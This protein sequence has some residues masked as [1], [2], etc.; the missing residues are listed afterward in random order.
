[1]QLEQH[2]WTEAEGWSPAPPGGL[3]GKA[4]LVLAFVATP[5]LERPTFLDDLTEA[6]P[7]ANVIVCSTAGEIAGTRVTDDSVV[8]TAFAFEHTQ[9]R[10]ACLSGSEVRD[11][12]DAGEILA[13]R[14]AG[15]DLVHILVLSDG[16]RVNGSSLV[17]GLVSQLPPTVTVTGGLAGDGERFDETF[18]FEGPEVS[19]EL[20]VGI[21][22]YGESLRIGHGSLGGWDPFGPERLITR[23]EENVLYELDGRSALGLYRKYL[24]DYARDLP[25]SALLFPLAVRSSSGRDAVV[26]TVLAIDDD[27]QTMT[28]AGDLPEG[29]YARLMKANFERLIDGATVAARVTCDS[30]GGAT[31]EFALLISCVGRKMV[32]RQ[33]I[34]EE[35]ESV[36]EIF[37]DET[38]MAGFYSYGEISPLVPAG[39]CEL[40]NQ[41]MTI[42]TFS[43][44]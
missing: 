17:D 26:R 44:G 23:S 32:L 5:L 8:A 18:V 19:Q 15:K 1:M 40:H 6:Y 24:G 11:S 30:I 2:T 21:G 9:V 16:T 31:P 29:Y 27:E 38:T 35:V 4:Q 36:R 12:Q 42:T 3:A 20:V 13:Q 22:F 33:R 39:R 43:E 10:S 37:G 25:A 14:L 41:T 28:F 7:E 34:E